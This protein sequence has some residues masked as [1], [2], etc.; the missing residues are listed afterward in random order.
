KVNM[1]ASIGH[2]AQA[3]F[4]SRRSHEVYCCSRN[5]LCCRDFV[6]LANLALD[7]IEAKFVY[8]LLCVFRWFSHRFKLGISSGHKMQICISSACTG[9]RLESSPLS[10]A[11]R[12]I[13]SMTSGARLP[14]AG[15][16]CI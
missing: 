7:V 16:F 6:N 11:A 1:V 9:P 2:V 5:D 3:N 10:S 8:A 13:R 15:G 4:D 14:P 12:M